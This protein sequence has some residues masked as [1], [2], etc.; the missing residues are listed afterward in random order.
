MILLGLLTLELILTAWMR[1]YEK[2][3]DTYDL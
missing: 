2:S 3:A 1:K